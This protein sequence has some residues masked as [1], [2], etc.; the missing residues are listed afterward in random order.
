M[1]HERISMD[2][3]VMMGKP[4]IRSTR[5]TVEVIL[6]MLGQGH[7]VDSLVDAYPGLT[8]AD[9]LAAQAFAGDY[10]ANERVTAAE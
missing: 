5:I 3:K 9:I 1:A 10:L 6:K 8:P 7:S 2:P 4:V